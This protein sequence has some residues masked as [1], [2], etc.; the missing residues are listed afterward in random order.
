MARR[1]KDKPSKAALTAFGVLGLYV[2]GSAVGD[3][4]IPAAAADAAKKSEPSSKPAV[5]GLKAKIR[6]C[7]STDRYAVVN[8]AG[9][10]YGA[11]QFMDPLWHEVM[12][13]KYRHASDAP[14]AVQDQA[15]D[16]AYA[17]YGTRPWTES[18]PCWSRR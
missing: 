8:P 9:P 3:P 10:A 5:T 12:G 14:A 6:Y 16:K 11:Y 4:E 18:K 15:F 17:K 7:E 1:K 13:N 2:L